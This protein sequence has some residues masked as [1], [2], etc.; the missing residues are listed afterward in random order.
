VRELAAEL[1]LWVAPRDDRPHVEL[2]GASDEHILLFPG[3]N[4]VSVDG[5]AFETQAPVLE[6]G[7]RAFVTAEDAASI[8]ALWWGAVARATSGSR[9]VRLPPP[10]DPLPLHRASTGTTRSAPRL[11][12]QR[13]PSTSTAA[14]PAERRAWGV[15]LRRTWSYLVV[16]HSAGTAGSAASFHT[17]HKARGWDGLGYH[18]VIGNGNGV[19][20]GGIE[21]GYRWTQQRAGAHAGQRTMNEHGIGI[22]LVGNFETS[23]PTPRQM[24][25]LTRLC[26]FLASHC[27][28]GPAGVRRHGDVR[29]TACPG[30]WFPR[31]WS[32]LDEPSEFRERS[33]L[34]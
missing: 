30:R 23:R 6:S 20:D 10:P 1:G 7:G 15:R 5:V 24:E 13:A 34:R 29:D 8:R 9:R 31:D 4:R 32:Y 18:F 28:I 2:I 17:A 3:T 16:H 11:A 21:V 22:C 33:A 27:N 12:P 19:P 14:L 25:S 26:R